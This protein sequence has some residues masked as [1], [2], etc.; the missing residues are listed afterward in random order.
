MLKNVNKRFLAAA[1][2]G[3]I[4]FSLCSCRSNKK[5]SVDI[6][7]STTLIST[8]DRVSNLTK[9]DENLA[10]FQ[11]ECEDGSKYSF[12]ELVDMYHEARLSE[13]VGEAN[14]MLYRIG[15]MILKASVAEELN[16][17]VNSISNVYGGIVD[18]NS[19]ICELTIKY[20]KS[21]TEE[22]PG[23]FQVE[24][25]EKE[26]KKIICGD[27]LR[28]LLINIDRARVSGWEIGESTG[29]MNT[30]IDDAYKAFERYFCTSGTL[31][32]SFGSTTLTMS[33]DENKV[34]AYEKTK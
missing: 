32:E 28:N 2:A 21:V 3:V 5:V 10:S 7:N 8:L 14:L 33:L 27:E 15:N 30:N 16:L 12:E 9:I 26:T 11:Y 1:M 25:V 24:D 19:G 34:E 17:D 22:I 6:S 18:Y 4:T 23:G 29:Y 13:N 20:N 31:K